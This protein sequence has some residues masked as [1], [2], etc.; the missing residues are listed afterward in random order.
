VLNGWR[1]PLLGY[2]LG[3]DDKVRIAVASS[4][5]LVC[6]VAPDC[7]TNRLQTKWGLFMT[8]Y[9][10]NN[11]LN[12]VN[13]VDMGSD[14]ST[15]ADRI[16]WR[17]SKQA[18]RGEHLVLWKRHRAALFQRRAVVSTPTSNIRSSRTRLRTLCR[19]K[20]SR[21]ILDNVIYCTRLFP[22]VFE[23]AGNVVVFPS[24]RAWQYQ[25]RVRIRKPGLTRLRTISGETLSPSLF[26]LQWQ[27]ASIAHRARSIG[28]S[29]RFQMVCKAIIFT[30]VL[31]TF[32][33]LICRLS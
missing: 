29:E 11:Y 33:L 12:Y 17:A 21:V 13:G 30:L 23:G 7:Q 15:L 18:I 19:R 8:A 27:L 16:Y 22:R 20:R 24:A 26:H 28:E 5:L 3:I 31:A 2:D 10:S 6:T 9:A 1:A 14:A 32:V 4:L 25:S